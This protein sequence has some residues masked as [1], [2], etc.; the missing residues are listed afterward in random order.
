MLN[1]DAVLDLLKPDGPLARVFQRFEPRP[2]QKEMMRH[3]LEAYNQKRICLVEAGTGTGKSLAYLIPALLWAV[4][5]K[6]RTV[7]A[8]HTIPLQ[9]QL[10]HKDVPLIAQA[11]R[12]E[13]QVEIVKGMQNYLC[14]KKFAEAE[15]DFLFLSPSE[16]QEWQKLSAWKAQTADG[17]RSSIPFP[18]SPALWDKMAAES[19]LCNRN[20]CPFYQQCHF[21][22]A[23]QRAQNAQLLIVNHHL[24]FS[25]LVAR[26][27]ADA[28]P[29]SN[30]EK[31]AGILPSYSRV[32]IDEAHQ[33][34]DVATEFFAA[35]ISQ[36]E[37]MRTLGR[38]AAEKGGKVQGRLPFLK[39]KMGSH[40][41]NHMPQPAASLYQRLTFDLP[42]LRQE[43]THQA[44][45]TFDAFYAFVAAVQAKISSPGEQQ[46]QPENR[47]R[48]LPQHQEHEVWKSQ[49]TSAAEQLLHILRKY[50]AALFALVEDFK[51]LK[52]PQLEDQCKGSIYE[53]SSLRLRLEG[54]AA[55]LQ[56]FMSDLRA[57]RV[58]W[59][60]S[61][62]LKSLVATTL[63][64]ADLDI[65]KILVQ[66]LFSKFATI[67]LCSA[68][69]TTNRQF[70]FMRQR[71]GLTPEQLPDRQVEAHFY[72]SP[73]D[74]KRQQLFLVPTDLP[75]PSARDFVPAAAAA[76]LKVVQASRG[77]AFVLFTSNA[78]L[79]ECFKLLEKPLQEAR[80][81][82][83][84]QGEADRK[85]LLDKFKST[86]RSVLFATSSFLGR[87]RCGGRI[88]ALRD[89]NET[90]V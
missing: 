83:L 18:V 34:E 71:L 66:Q 20:Q 72:E 1:I 74:F 46:L 78:M 16:M 64:E 3:V 12:L 11:L 50:A 28:L 85:Q 5:F 13:L 70:D 21:F 22:K 89:L 86:N 31:E 23:R 56:N 8:T 80:L 90:A 24:L 58:R 79:Q 52:N 87:H 60:E 73:F 29:N 27:E 69:L 75:D 44:H 40:Y 9:E 37:I 47:L 81:V 84:R 68:T 82:P 17:S 2:E 54:Y 26:M 7:I 55:L 49:L 45:H 19:D 15:Q 62:P 43:L 38:L 51:S 4:Q 53:I 25:D 32:I 67:V 61:H 57:G 10:L 48:V 33:I 65:S 59:I 36:L 39:E 14:L 88:A 77:N 42:G 6:E 41:Q 63:V 76:I 30:K 35:S